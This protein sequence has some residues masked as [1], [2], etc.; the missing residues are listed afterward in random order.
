MVLGFQ[1]QRDD[2]VCNYVASKIARKTLHS[3]LCSPK[4]DLAIRSQPFDYIYVGGR[5]H[6]IK[7]PS[8]HSHRPSLLFGYQYQSISSPSVWNHL[9]HR[10]NQQMNLMPFF[11]SPNNLLLYCAGPASAKVEMLEK[12]VETGMNIARLNFS[13][14]SY[15][16]HGN[17]IA[18]VRQAVKNLGD[19]LKM[20][21]PVAIALDTKGPEIRT[22]LLEGVCPINVTIRHD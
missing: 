11:F 7:C 8:Q 10:Y 3:F 12:M 13:H 14:G 20:T 17:T 4:T 18:S 16:Y 19:K 22:G 5:W 15:E 9:H 2:V 21:V 1:D 6:P